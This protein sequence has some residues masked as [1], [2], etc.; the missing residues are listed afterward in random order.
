MRSLNPYLPLDD[1][2]LK[3][4]DSTAGRHIRKRCMAQLWP[5][6]YDANRLLQRCQSYSVSAHI[7]SNV[8][9]ETRERAA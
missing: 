7:A 5:F 6:C 9:S 3:R 2:I 4:A 1:R 8:R